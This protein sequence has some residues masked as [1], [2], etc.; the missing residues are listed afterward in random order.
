MSNDG[1][2]KETDDKWEKI[3]DEAWKRV[4]FIS[5][6]FLISCW[7]YKVISNSKGKELHARFISTAA[8]LKEEAKDEW[9]IVSDISEMKLWRFNKL[10][11]K[12]DDMGHKVSLLASVLAMEMVFKE[13]G[14]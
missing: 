7:E 3:Q 5:E 14:E 12:L 6:I 9:I 10:V 1:R 13:E 4:T 8:R 11:D 2:C